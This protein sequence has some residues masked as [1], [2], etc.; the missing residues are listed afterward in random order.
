MKL[1]ANAS[2]LAVLPLVR[3]SGT[4]RISSALVRIAAIVLASQAT[5][6]AGVSPAGA[7]WLPHGSLAQPPR[8]RPIRVSPVFASSLRTLAA[9]RPGLVAADLD[10][11][12]YIVA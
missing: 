4:A 6:E 12:P 11:G 3:L 7:C 5:L 2:W 8:R 9:Q 10:L 1:V